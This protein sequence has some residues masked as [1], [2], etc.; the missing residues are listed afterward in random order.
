MKEEVKEDRINM[1]VTKR[2]KEAFYLIVDYLKTYSK[3]RNIAESFTEILVAW[4]FKELDDTYG[5]IRCC[6]R[7]GTDITKLNEQK[8]E[9]N[10]IWEILKTK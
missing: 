3:I 8:K 9:L 7:E 2:K 6:E 4:T 1:R 10:K 5:S